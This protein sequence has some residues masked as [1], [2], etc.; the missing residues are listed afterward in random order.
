MKIAH[1]S[2]FHIDKNYKKSNYRRSAKLLEFIAGNNFDHIIVS[3]DITEN[4]EASAFE[5]TRNLFK[6]Y[7]LLDHNKLTLTIGNHDIYGG[8]HLAEDV[9][10]FPSKCKTTSY[11]Q[12]VNEFGEYYKET[13]RNTIRLFKNNLFPHIKIFDEFVLIVLNSNAKYSRIKNPFASNGE[14]L[15]GHLEAAGKALEMPE[16]KNKHRIVVTHHHFYKQPVEDSAGSSSTIWQAIERQTL[17]LRDKKRI[18]KQFKKLD[19]KNCFTWPCA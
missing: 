18:I 17:K 5:M 19:V 1:I 2:D 11:E 9:I 14:I 8:V 12:K 16:L 4:A 13:F 7:G 3:G 6:K 15:S 10:N